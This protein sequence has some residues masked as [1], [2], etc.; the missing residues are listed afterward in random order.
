VGAG[1]RT[2][3]SLEMR[4]TSHPHSS[5]LRL[6]RRVTPGAFLITKCLDPRLKV[7]D[8]TIATEICSALCFYARKGQIH[9]A[10]FVVMLDHW[11][12]VLAIADGKNISERM[13]II[14]SWISKQTEAPLKVLGCGWQQGFHDTEIRSAKQFQFVCV[15]LEENPVRVGLVNSPSDWRWSSANPKYHS[16]LTRT[17]P[18]GF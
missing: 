3:I 14:D 16:C 12:A 2:A 15:Y 7:I 9:L 18:W 4:Q 11:H 8:C 5:R 6:H 1:L 13:N 17:W 10:A